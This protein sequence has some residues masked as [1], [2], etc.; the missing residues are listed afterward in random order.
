MSIRRADI[1]A[2]LSMLNTCLNPSECEHRYCDLIIRARAAIQQPEEDA[3]RD[4]LRARVTCL[5]EARADLARIVTAKVEDGGLWVRSV[6]EGRIPLLDEAIANT[7]AVLSGV[8]SVHEFYIAEGSEQVGSCSQPH[9]VQEQ[10]RDGLP[11]ASGSEGRENLAG[12]PSSVDAP[13]R[14][15]TLPPAP[16]KK[17]PAEYINGKWEP[18]CPYGDWCSR[19]DAIGYCERVKNE[20]RLELERQRLARKHVSSGNRL[21]FTYRPTPPSGPPPKEQG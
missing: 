12:T 14:A 19:C 15:A 16:E 6:A 20:R 11:S 2:D 7:Y 21:G 8:P 5:V 17:W 18:Q 13:T 3:L 1:V 10:A 4:E 9:P